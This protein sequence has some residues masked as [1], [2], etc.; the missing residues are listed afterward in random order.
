MNMKMKYA[1]VAGA[2]L[3]GAGFFGGALVAQ[4]HKG[5]DHGGHNHNGMQ[6]DMDP[7]AMMEAYLEMGKP[8]VQHAKLAAFTGKWDQTQ[9]HWMEP[10]APPMISEAKYSSEMIMGGRYMVD[11]VESEFMGTPFEGR[12]ITGY[13]RAAK[14]FFSV[15]YDSFGTGLMIT[16]GDFN[17]KGELVMEGEWSDPMSPS[18]KSWV[19][20]K[21]TIVSS[22]RS[23]F[24]M[25][26]KGP[27][28]AKTKMMEINSTR[29]H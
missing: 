10:T 6:G 13:D 9:K 2:A 14:R 12:G 1:I 24:E 25:W 8:V 11:H 19:K 17:D 15:W 27:D 26:G 18:G 22:D 28:G 21:A 23:K 4:D 20:T 7:A 3:V 16:Y 29:A 5:H